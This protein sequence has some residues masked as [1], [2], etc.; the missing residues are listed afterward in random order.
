MSSEQNKEFIV[1][2]YS[3]YWQMLRWHISASW[4][5][6][7]L[8][9]MIVFGILGLSIDKL[10]SNYLLLSI[11]LLV[12]SIFVAIILVHHN[13][14]LLWVKYFENALKEL[15]VKHGE[16]KNVY[17]SQISP[18]LTGMASIS[19]SILLGIFLG[20]CSLIFFISSIYL[21]FLQIFR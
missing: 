7:A 18:S 16:L 12:C 21:L 11:T 1:E 20:L 10:R 4:N 2:Q 13:R 3:Q 19:S 9:L 14:N 6:P 8:S 5:I 17:H 15:E